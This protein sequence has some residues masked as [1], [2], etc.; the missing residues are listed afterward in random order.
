[1]GT[2]GSRGAIR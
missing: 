2:D 1:M